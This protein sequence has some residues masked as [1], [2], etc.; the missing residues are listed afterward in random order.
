MIGF[1]RHW[2]HLRNQAEEL[3]LIPAELTMP[4]LS[5]AESTKSK[6]SNAE[7]TKTVFTQSVLT[8]AGSSIKAGSSFKAE[9][10]FNAVTIKIEGVHR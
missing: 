6:L 5:N 4:E 9:S 7:L 8:K 10:M 2:L 1:H 3:C